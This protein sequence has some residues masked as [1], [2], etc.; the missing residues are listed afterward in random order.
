MYK[1]ETKI[2]NVANNLLFVPILILILKYRSEIQQESFGRY[3][4]YYR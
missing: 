2:C 3:T 4:L 1:T